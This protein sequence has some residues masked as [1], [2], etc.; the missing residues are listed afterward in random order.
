MKKT[1]YYPVYYGK[2]L[3]VGL[4]GAESVSAAPRIE[5]GSQEVTVRVTLRYQIKN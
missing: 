4:G 1:N 3:A 2:D 5:A